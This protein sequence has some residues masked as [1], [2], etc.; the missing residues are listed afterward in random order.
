ML[1]R[2]STA[3][4]SCMK[5]PMALRGAGRHRSGRRRGHLEVV[6]VPLLVLFVAWQVDRLLTRNPTA[7]RRDAARTILLGACEREKLP[8]HP[9][10]R[11]VVDHGR[12]AAKVRTPVTVVVDQLA[13]DVRQGFGTGSRTGPSCGRVGWSS[14]LRIRMTRP[15][16]PGKAPIPSHRRGHAVAVAPCGRLSATRRDS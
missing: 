13:V 7:P 5:R 9:A 8:L 1:V 11:R 2:G 15:F 14:W 6:A 4:A 16:G 3:T 10:R 12:R